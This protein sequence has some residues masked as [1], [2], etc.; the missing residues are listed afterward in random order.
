MNKLDEC[1]DRM[2]WVVLSWHES[3]PL[4][5]TCLVVDRL[6]RVAVVMAMSIM[7]RK[8]RLGLGW[9]MTHACVDRAMAAVGQS[10]LKRS[11]HRP[12]DRETR[13]FCPIPHS[14]HIEPHRI[15]LEMRDHE[16]ARG[17]LMSSR[18]GGSEASPGS[19]RRRSCG[20]GVSS[21]PASPA[22]HGHRWNQ[23]RVGGA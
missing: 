8:R 4:A 3:T 6:T 22:V 23:L 16:Y 9:L 10:V 13:G 21:D 12:H 7:E 2:P 19:R 14:D 5:E 17:R 15:H 18:N 1:I 11:D 20:D